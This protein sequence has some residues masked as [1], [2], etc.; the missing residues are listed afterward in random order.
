MA[1][2]LRVLVDL[3]IVL[4]VLAERQPHYDASA[5][6]WAAVESGEIQGL[7]AAHSLTTLFYLLCKH[8]NKKKAT[9]T[10]YD[11]LQVYEIAALDNKIMRNALM[12]GWDDYEDA[13]QM[14]AATDANAD[15]LVTRNP[16]DFAG[17]SVPVLQPGDLLALLQSSN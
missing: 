8:T 9:Q 3:N 4:D 12:L 13:V 6:V 2:K 15:Y 17:D 5:R 16:K 7:L 10:L 14:A 1:S 11:L